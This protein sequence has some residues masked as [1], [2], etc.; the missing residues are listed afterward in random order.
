MNEQ[1]A[2]EERSDNCYYQNDFV[3]YNS[4]VITPAP[5]T[6]FALLQPIA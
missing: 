4:M 6:E 3:L 2:K 1:S 5:D